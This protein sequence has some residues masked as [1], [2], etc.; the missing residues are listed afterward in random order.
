MKKAGERTLKI[1]GETKSVCPV[2]LR[3][4]PARLESGEESGGEVVRLARSCPEHGEFAEAI[5]RGEPAFADWK[6]PKKPVPPAFA[7]T[8]RALGCPRDCGRCEEHRQQACTVLFEITRHCNLRCPVCFAS[9]GT[10]PGAKTFTPLSALR[11]RLHWIRSQT[12]EIVLQISGGEPTLHP[13]LPA[14]VQAARDLFP[15]VQLNTNGLLLAGRPELAGELAQAGLSWVFLQFDGCSDAVYRALRGRDLFEIKKRAVAACARAGLAVVLVPT[16]ARGVNERELG[17]ILDFALVN[18]PTVRGLHIQPM[19][20]FGRNRLAKAEALTLPEVLRLL[21]E[22]S[23]GRI[24][25]EHATAPGC[26]HERCSFHCRYRLDGRGGLIPLRPAENEGCCNPP[27][28]T[29]AT[30]GE[31]G[32]GMERAVKTI[33]RS[34]SAPEKTEAAASC[35]P[36]GPAG[37]PAPE[38]GPEAEEDALSRFIR[39]ARQRAF[40]VTCMAFQDARALD[41]ERLQSCCVHVF[42]PGK[43]RHRLVPFCAYNLTAL[44][45]TALHRKPDAAAG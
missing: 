34:W 35:A 10:E 43:D 19:A 23:G 17:A 22:Q 2:C 13:D 41:L 28:G 45:G 31:A 36:P 3:V 32:D 6:R 4:L 18:A 39:E 14:V 37:T 9:S 44:D 25:P 33:I 20:D 29:S 11:E 38:A 42:A 12:G 7:Q 1:L 26:E 5:W 24:R 15:A 21:A 16:L 27:S 30:G 40:S 8:R